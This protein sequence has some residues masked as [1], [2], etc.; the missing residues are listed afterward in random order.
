MAQI[1]LSYLDRF[2]GEPVRIENRVDPD[3]HQDKT[4]IE[5]KGRLMPGNRWGKISFIEGFLSDKDNDGKIVMVDMGDG[6]K[7]PSWSGAKGCLPSSLPY[8][9]YT[10]T[11]WEI[12]R[13]KDSSLLFSHRQ[14]GPSE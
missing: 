7:M 9:G 4:S 14:V 12:Q 11:V 8:L 5:Q 13:L 10:R 3:Y 2:A 1:D 6:I